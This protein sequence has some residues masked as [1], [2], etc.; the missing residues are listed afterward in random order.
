MLIWFLVT[1]ILSKLKNSSIKIV[2]TRSASMTIF[3]P[4]CIPNNEIVRSL[5]H[6]PAPSPNCAFAVFIRSVFLQSN[7][8]LKQRYISHCPTNQPPHAPKTHESFSEGQRAF[9]V[10]RHL[11]FLSHYQPVCVFVLALNP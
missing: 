8:I 7:L 6:F 10:R 5:N 3:L 9:S 11:I 2:R 1:C 4:P